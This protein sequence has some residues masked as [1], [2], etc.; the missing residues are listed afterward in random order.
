[1]SE[2]D[3]RGHIARPSFD[4]LDII[5]SYKN[6]SR[7]GRIVRRFYGEAFLKEIESYSARG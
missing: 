4:F 7:M 6:V 1:M 2:F 5:A 3:G